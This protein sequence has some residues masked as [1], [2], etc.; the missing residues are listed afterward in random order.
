MMDVTT[1]SD[2]RNC[3]MMSLGASM[4]GLWVEVEGEC[5]KHGRYVTEAVINPATGKPFFTVMCPYC[6]EELERQ[7]IAE[8]DRQEAE[9][10]KLAEQ[11][12]AEKTASLACIP[13]CFAGLDFKSFYTP[14]MD[15]LNAVTAVRGW[16]RR[17]YRGERDKPWLILSGTVGTGKTHLACVCMN[18]L[19]S[20]CGTGLYASASQIV[21]NVT[22][23]WREK[24]D[25][26]ESAVKKTLSEVGLLIVDEV[27]RGRSTN[28]LAKDVLFEIMDE[29]YTSRK[30]TIFVTN[31]RSQDLQKTVDDAM[32][33]RMRHLGIFV[34]MDWED[35]RGKWN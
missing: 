14:T 11:K 9:A 1:N 26:T 2:R 22:S 5:E 21:S 7:R 4:T 6:H 16:A 8:R 20:Q 19:L 28:D 33:S 27:G 17:I 34:P 18:Q 31:C 35:Q 10:R 24:A 25:T 23:T 3:K 13:K 15:Q 32:Y 30:P 12:A 29:R